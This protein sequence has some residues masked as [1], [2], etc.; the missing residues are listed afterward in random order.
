MAIRRRK[1]NLEDGTV[2]TRTKRGSLESQTKKGTPNTRHVLSIR[3]Y[4]SE[5][6]PVKGYL[7][8]DDVVDL[9]GIVP[10]KTDHLTNYYKL[11]YGK[12]Q[13]GYIPCRFI[14]E[15]EPWEMEERLIAFSTP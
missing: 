9:V 13:I 4:A 3:G 8:C 5:Y 2:K 6:A 14:R 10:G 1:V 12:H 15:V 7:D 11:R